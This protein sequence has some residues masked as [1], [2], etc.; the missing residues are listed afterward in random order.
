MRGWFDHWGYDG[1]TPVT[2]DGYTFTYAELE[3][4][5]EIARSAVRAIADAPDGTVV[6][7][8]LCFVDFEAYSQ[9]DVDARLAE[10][11]GYAEDVVA[12]VRDRDIVLILGNALPRVSAETTPEI[13]DLHERYNRRLEE[14]AKADENVA[15]FD[16]YGPLSSGGALRAKFA[17]SPG[18]S[19]LNEAAYTLL[20]T[21]FFAELDRITGR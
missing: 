3:S 11:I 1:S 13:R 7:F 6:F 16:L 15:V 12:A 9:T 20:D 17:A 8:K 21:S 10:N 19:H 18:D 14:L 4:P 2:R 5:P